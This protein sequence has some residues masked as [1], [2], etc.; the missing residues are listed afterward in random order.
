[1]GVDPNT[2]RDLLESFGLPGGDTGWRTHEDTATRLSFFFTERD[3]SAPPENGG[4]IFLEDVA[5]KSGSARQHDRNTTV[6]NGADEEDVVLVPPAGAGAPSDVVL[7]RE[8]A[9]SERGATSRRSGQTSTTTLSQEPLWE[10]SS[11]RCA[12]KWVEAP[13]KASFRTF[14]E[15]IRLLKTMTNSRYVV[16]IY[17]AE[18][19][20]TSGKIGIVM[21]LA[22]V[23]ARSECPPRCVKGEKK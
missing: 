9:L 7:S 8:R 10:M 3:P 15:E 1:M 11:F 19:D 18:L 20:E 13:S 21:E 23:E 22:E 4:S 2:S 17:D 5:G 12:I 14:K 16:E 6:E